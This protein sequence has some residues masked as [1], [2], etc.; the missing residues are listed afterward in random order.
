MVMRLPIALGSWKVE[1]DLEYL[2]GRLLESAESVCTPRFRVEPAW[3]A[4]ESWGPRHWPCCRCRW[5]PELLVKPLWHHG[6]SNWA[7]S[8][9]P[10]FLACSLV[11]RWALK[12]RCSPQ[13]TLHASHVR[14]PSRRGA[15]SVADM[16]GGL[17][18]TA[19]S[20]RRDGVGGVVEGWKWP[21]STRARWCS[22]HVEESAVAGA[23]A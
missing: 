21:A 10:V 2:V 22:R 23:G 8:G 15:L 12:A 6:H 20:A 18:V 4:S 13:C 3:V 5:T 7:G 1:V 9:W 11:R 14:P 17:E 19:G 16:A